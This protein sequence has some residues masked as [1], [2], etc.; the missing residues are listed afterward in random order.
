MRPRPLS[1]LKQLAGALTA[2]AAT[3]GTAATMAAPLTSTVRDYPGVS[4]EMDSGSNPCPATLPVTIRANT[5][6]ELRQPRLLA[7]AMA[8]AQITAQTNCPASTQID[9]V[10]VVS[11]A[12]VYSAVA[13]RAD[14]WRL[15]ETAPPAPTAPVAAGP[16]PTNPQSPA[17][18]VAAASV[19]TPQADARPPAPAAVAAPPVPAVVQRCDSLAAHPDD[20]EAFAA[21]VPDDRLNAAAAI[22]A[23]EAALKV[24]P[25]APRLHFQLGRAYLKGNRFEAAT[26]QFIAAAQDGHGGALAHLADIHLGGAPGIEA[27]PML[28]KTLYEQALAA[29]FLP[30]ADVL[31]D[32]EDKTDEYEKAEAEEAAANAAQGAGP[33]ALKPYV[34]PDIMD[35]IVSRNFDAIP[36]NES[37]VKE[38][39]FNI[40]DNIRAICE[41]NFT[42]QEVDRLKAE[43][44][45][46]HFNLGQAAAGANLMSGM[47][48]LAQAMKNPAAFMAPPQAPAQSAND[49]PFEV[50]M[51][52]TEALFQRHVCKTPGMGQFTKNLKAY[53]QNDDAPL[54]APNALVNACLRDPPQS[55]YKPSDFCLCF[56]GG[57]RNAR[58]SQANRK[59]LLKNFQAAATRI[60]E[61]DKNRPVF[62]ACRSGF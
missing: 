15:V 47:A 39:L 45:A 33:G 4:V 12:I 31:K 53:V 8:W 2:L 36:Y 59:D 41:S 42:Q 52:D 1:P 20:P 30:A 28:A 40:A 6:D 26:E 29:G 55:R 58:V 7:R 19:A 24:D 3:F 22:T 5:P 13:Q 43:A 9:V 57:L 37:W 46:D 50:G 16:A 51:K 54:P 17:A 11:G 56:S 32:F 23:C 60:M 61:I 35:N 27:D 21:G 44:D 25:S 18:P 62:Q 38:Y 49:D 34:M 10:G 14:N 48:I